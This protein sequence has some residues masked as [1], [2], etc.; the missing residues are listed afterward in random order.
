MRARCPPWLMTR[1]PK[2]YGPSP[3]GYGPQGGG[4]ARRRRRLAGAA[5]SP[6]AHPPF[7]P[8]PP[9]AAATLCLQGRNEAAA[10]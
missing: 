7:I 5:L 4:Q 6:T 9:R 10:I 8:P 3:E 2:S 1:L